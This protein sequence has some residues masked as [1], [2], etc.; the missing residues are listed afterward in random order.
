MR[1]LYVLVRMLH[2]VHGFERDL[3]RFV[4]PQRTHGHG[5]VVAS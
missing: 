2:P 1:Q 4:Q 5:V 3:A